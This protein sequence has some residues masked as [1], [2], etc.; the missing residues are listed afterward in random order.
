L[1]K[2]RR[3]IESSEELPPLKRAGETAAFGLRM[4]AG[5]PFEEFQRATNFDLR[6]E[7]NSEMSQLTERG[8]AARDAE[9]FQ[10]TH[11]G[12]RFAD[13]AAELFLR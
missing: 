13:S 5:W 2:G 3:A 10:L 1:D 6:D 9:K 12:L 4:N 8:W 7:W 11:E